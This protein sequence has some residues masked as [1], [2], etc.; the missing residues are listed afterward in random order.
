MKNETQG[1]T[2]ESGEAEFTTLVLMF[3]TA[4]MIHLGAAPDPASG[5]TKADLAQAN[6]MIDLLEVLRTKTAGNLT[7]EES[8]MIDDLLFDL[9]MRYLEAV[10]RA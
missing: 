1:R 6:R 10:K 9:R 4:A 5:E 3:S 8:A 7:V 2:K